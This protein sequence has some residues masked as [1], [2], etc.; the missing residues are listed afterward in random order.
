MAVAQFEHPLLKHTIAGTWAPPAPAPALSTSGAAGPARARAHV[1]ALDL[2]SLDQGGN[3]H[4]KGIGGGKSG[5]VTWPGSESTPLASHRAQDR[6]VQPAVAPA[7]QP[8]GEGEGVVNSQAFGALQVKETLFSARSLSNI[9]PTPVLGSPL[10][11]PGPSQPKDR[12]Q[13]RGG[14]QLCLRMHILRGLGKTM[15]GAATAPSAPAA[16]KPSGARHALRRL[17]GQS[18]AVDMDAAAVSAPCEPTASG[19]PLAIKLRTIFYNHSA[20]SEAVRL[21][22]PIAGR[23]DLHLEAQLPIPDELLPY[24]RTRGADAATQQQS[25]QSPLTAVAQR[26]GPIWPLLYIQVVSSC[27]SEVPL[28]NVAVGHTGTL[29][30]SQDGTEHN[31][32]SAGS[33][34][35]G[36]QPLR[37]A[38]AVVSTP[39]AIEGDARVGQS[40]QPE[41]AKP[42]PGVVDAKGTPTAAVQT[43]KGPA[44]LTPRASHAQQSLLLEHITSRLGLRSLRQK[45]LKQL[46]ARS[47]RR[48]P[49]TPRVL[50]SCTVD[51]S[52]LHDGHIAHP[53]LNLDGEGGQIECTL[54]ME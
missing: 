38:G 35:S 50:A 52:R 2:S 37:D 42:T 45:R 41:Q 43:A 15:K 10:A 47:M 16:H 14:T 13:G 9:R 25:S 17:S 11:T 29:S 31:S 1:P 8:T 54:S 5:A 49:S 24:T 26:Y 48:L 4:G 32:G 46:S 7:G 39:I 18:G 21:N 27:L 44:M 6:P 36:E 3:G 40:Q 30:G 34:A 53:V 33:A 28:A 51:V 23:Q 12:T 20:T 22:H 19:I